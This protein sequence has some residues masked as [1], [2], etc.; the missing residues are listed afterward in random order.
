MHGL[1]RF[2]GF[3][4]PGLDVGVSRAQESPKRNLVRMLGLAAHMNPLEEDA[5]MLGCPVPLGLDPGGLDPGGFEA[6]F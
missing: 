6:W 2:L 5:R 1:G 3:G 4:Q